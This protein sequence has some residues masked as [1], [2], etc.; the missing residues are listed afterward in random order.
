MPTALNKLEGLERKYA[1]LLGAQEAAQGKTATQVRLQ[2][3]ALEALIR[4]NIDPEWTSDHI[5]PRHRSAKFDLAEVRSTIVKVLPSDQ[6][7][8]VREIAR[9]VAAQM[10]RP[11]LDDREL[12]NLDGLVRRALQTAPSN[13]VASVGSRPQR[14]I[15]KTDA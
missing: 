3:R 5:E 7:S 12:R 11:N 2:M 8:T 6:P 14:W 1:L 4:S 10:Q 9:L 15:R 13:E